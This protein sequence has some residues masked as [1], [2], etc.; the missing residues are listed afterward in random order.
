M[1]PFTLYTT[2]AYAAFAVV[3][4]ALLAYVL[5]RSAAAKRTLEA[6][7]RRGRPEG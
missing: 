4:G 3:L 1:Q 7:E 5:T 2:L 6:A